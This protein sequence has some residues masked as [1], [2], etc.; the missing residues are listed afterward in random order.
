MA[1]NHAIVFVYTV[2]IACL[3]FIYTYHLYVVNVK[4]G[5]LMTEAKP[6]SKPEKMESSKKYYEKVNKESRAT[7]VSSLPSITVGV[8]AAILL[9]LFGNLIF[10][11]IAEGIEWFGYPLPQILTFIILVGLAVFVLRILVDVRRAVDALAGLA[12]CEIGAPSDVTPTEVDHYKTAM[13]G[14]LYVIIISL[15]FLLFSDYLARI[16]PALSGVALIAIVVWG[17]FEIW[18][19]V[20]AVSKEIRRYSSE[21]AG[22]AL[23]VE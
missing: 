22:K 23:K 16:H 5:D 18:R 1:G 17:I 3:L 7:L 10:I 4:R 15:A 13:R 2:Y 6:P 11:P 20:K 14:I 8:I 21:W 19:A 12:A 9:W